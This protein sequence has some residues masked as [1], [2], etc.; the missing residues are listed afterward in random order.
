MRMPDGLVPLL[1]LRALIAATQS[2]AV[3]LALA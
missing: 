3:P 1:D 2:A